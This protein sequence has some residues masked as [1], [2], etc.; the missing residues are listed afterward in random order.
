MSIETDYKQR[1]VY[2]ISE[3]QK[4]LFECN[5]LEDIERSITLVIEDLQSEKIDIQVEVDEYEVNNEPDSLEQQIKSAEKSLPVNEVINEYERMKRE[6][7]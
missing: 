3:F 5:D 1:L 6:G 4:E 7:F 2:L